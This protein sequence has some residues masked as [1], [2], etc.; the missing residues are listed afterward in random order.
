MVVSPTSPANLPSPEAWID[1]SQES[2]IADGLPVGTLNDK[3]VSRSYTT[4]SLSPGT[5]RTNV[6]NGLPVLRTTSGLTAYVASSAP[7]IA[8]SS[9][10]C[11]W[12]VGQSNGSDAIVWG[13]S[14]PNNQVR[15]NYTTNRYMYFYTGPETLAALTGTESTVWNIDMY[16]RDASNSV[17]LYLNGVLKNTPTVISSSVDLGRLLESY[18][19][20]FVGDFAEAGYN[21]ADFSKA[22]LNSLGRYL[23]NKWAIGWT[24]IA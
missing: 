16:V 7:V 5:Y 19:V 10:F 12:F 17:R 18:S 6:R 9:P 24:D 4:L 21:A 1:M 3:A 11:L 14:F 15:I 22:Q 13:N 23:G 8:S 20:P 2:A